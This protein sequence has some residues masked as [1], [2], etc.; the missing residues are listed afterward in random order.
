MSEAIITVGLGIAVV[1]FGWLIYRV[2]GTLSAGSETS[3]RADANAAGALPG[4]EHI[5]S[6]IARAKNE[7]NALSR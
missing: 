6:A 5:D 4:S 3:S 1:G 7:T 2:V